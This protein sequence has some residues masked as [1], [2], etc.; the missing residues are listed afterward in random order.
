MD[1]AD[2]SIDVPVLSEDSLLNLTRY[3][4]RVEDLAVHSC[5]HGKLLTYLFLEL[6]GEGH[7]E[8][9][10]RI[11]EKLVDLIDEERDTEHHRGKEADD[12]C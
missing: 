4:F 11:N 7:L 10:A 9:G 8:I 12:N 3:F 6:S 5:R 1:E 2:N